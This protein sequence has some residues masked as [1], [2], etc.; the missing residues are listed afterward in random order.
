ML[1]SQGKTAPQEA[2]TPELD[3]GHGRETVLWAETGLK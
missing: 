1:L 3:G 2:L